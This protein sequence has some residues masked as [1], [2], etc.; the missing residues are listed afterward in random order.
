MKTPKRGESGSGKKINPQAI[1]DSL[2]FQMAI[3]DEAGIVL[4]VNAAWKA[5]GMENGA[6]AATRAG[7][8][9]DYLQA[10]AGNGSNQGMRLIKE[11]AAVLSGD[12]QGFTTEYPCHGNHVK[13]WFI[14][15]VSALTAPW[16]GAVISHFKITERVQAERALR[17]AEAKLTA[18][19][20][21]ALASERSKAE[22]LAQMSHEIRTPLNGIIGMV[23]MLKDSR[24]DP[25]QRNTLETLDTLADHLLGIVNDVLDLAKIE[26]G[27]LTFEN[28]SLNPG[29]VAGS[30]LEILRRPAR[31]KGIQLRFESASDF[32]AHVLGDARRL[33]QIL[34]NLA[35]NAVKFTDQGSVAILAAA[36]SAGEGRLRLTFTVRDTGMGISPE[37]MEKLFRRF[38]QVEGGLGKVT[39]G[40]GLGLVISRHLAQGMGGDIVAKSAIGLG[41]EFTVAIVVNSAAPV[42]AQVGGTAPLPDKAD[43]AGPPAKKG[44]ILVADDNTVNRKIMAAGLEKLGWSVLLAKD[45]QEALAILAGEAVTA[46]FLD[47]QMPVMDGYVVA[48]TLRR[49]E[50]ELGSPR[51][52]VIAITA[53]A[54]EGNLERCRESGMDDL[55]LKPFRTAD[56]ARVLAGLEGAKWSRTSPWLP[57]PGA[58]PLPGTPSR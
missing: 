3:V 58:T 23:E 37:S 42:S 57:P 33:R 20:D 17:K 31:E 25:A 44:K 18:S 6:D 11:L 27:K 15:Q 38:S 34:L 16:K 40:T 2:P 49:L 22:F 51:L 26:A 30:V 8:G 53:D 56:I 55:L 36:E 24:L 7:V 54:M 14:M 12:S 35:G 28:A 1:I 21:A 13:R 43:P 5:F 4:H 52:P 9:Y 45:G 39:G 41:S 32:P 19:R 10:C 48:Q 46:L 29:Q 50:L 47:C